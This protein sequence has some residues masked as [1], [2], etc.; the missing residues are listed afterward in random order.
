MIV[1]NLLFILLILSKS[2]CSDREETIAE[3]QLKYFLNNVNESRPSTPEFQ[4][5]LETP[6]FG[7][8]K[9]PNILDRKKLRQKPS[10]KY[11]EKRESKN[12]QN[13][14]N[15][16]QYMENLNITPHNPKNT[17]DGNIFK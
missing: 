12:E 14:K 3:K 6:K 7:K 15:M 1:L 16:I 2:I 9:M 17:V 10:D 11:F 4:N 13:M 8:T 5:D